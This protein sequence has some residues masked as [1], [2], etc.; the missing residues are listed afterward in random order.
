MIVKAKV[1]M[2]ITC[3]YIFWCK[4]LNLVTSF[5]FSAHS[6]NRWWTNVWRLSKCRSFTI[7]RTFG[8]RWKVLTKLM[9]LHAHHIC[10]FWKVFLKIV[11]KFWKRSVLVRLLKRFGEYLLFLKSKISSHTTFVV[12]IMIM[13]AIIFFQWNFDL[14]YQQPSRR[15]PAPRSQ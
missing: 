2:C 14:V 1:I 9:A 12:Q 15:L 8:I 4:K 5:D 6:S 3:A 7:F 13:M 10:K 11:M